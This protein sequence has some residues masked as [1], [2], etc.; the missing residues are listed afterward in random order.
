MS[1]GKGLVT[2]IFAAAVLA[3]APATASAENMNAELLASGCAVCHGQGGASQGHI[4]SIDTLSAKAISQR[5]AEFRDGQRPAT[6]MK[7][8]A[9][10]YSDAQIDLIAGQLGAK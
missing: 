1:T 8:I 4:P 9:A 6:I 7:K 3:F 10:G 5:L 2:G